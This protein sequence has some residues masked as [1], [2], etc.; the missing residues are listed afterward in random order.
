[1]QQRTVCYFGTW[2]AGYARNQILIA[3]L[4][5]AGWRVLECHRTL[6]LSNEERVQAAAGGWRRPSLWWRAVCVYARLL[7]QYRGVGPYEV[8]VVGYPGVIDVF[9]ARLLTW[10]AGKPLVWDVLLSVYGVARERGFHQRSPWSVRLLN[11]IERLACRLPDLLVLD[12][13]Q[14]VAWF[15]G[16]YGLP[17]ERFRL[18]PLGAD[19]RLFRPLD[20]ADGAPADADHEFLVLYYG[21]FIPNHGVQ[22]IVEAARLLASERSIRFE[23][24]GQ[25]PDRAAA[26]GL[27]RQH[28]LGNLAFVDWLEQDELARRMARADVCLGAFGTSWLSKITIHNKV[29]EALAMAKPVITVDSPATRAVF[30]HG[31]HVYLCPGADPA[32]LATAILTLRA[33]PELRRRLAEEGFRLFRERFTVDHTGRCFAAHLQEVAR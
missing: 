20:P 30:A 23:L 24:V 11:V 13:P 5:R 12:T 9:F 16:T 14:H 29:F 8:M 33:R 27:A 28:N 17:A 3:G 22:N 4:R 18:V 19:D 1:M 2:R 7:W 10:L 6:W 26:E 25:G 32:A 31:T 15:R 21:S